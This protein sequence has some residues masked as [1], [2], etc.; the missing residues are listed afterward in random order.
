MC[1]CERDPNMPN[2]VIEVS[3]RMPLC[4]V[5]FDRTV[6]RHILNWMKKTSSRSHDKDEEQLTCLKTI[7]Y[8]TIFYTTCLP[9]SHDCPLIVKQESEAERR[10]HCRSRSCKGIS[11]SP[12]RT[13]ATQS[14]AR[15]KVQKG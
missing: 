12:I 13:I 3:R 15:I 14:R 5:R 10:T 2:S 9:H 8:R 6:K 7:N 11:I 4:E 1:K